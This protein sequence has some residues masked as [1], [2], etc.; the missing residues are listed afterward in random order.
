MKFQLG[1]INSIGKR[2][3]FLFI[4]QLIIIIFLPLSLL[5]QGLIIDHNCTDTSKIPDYWIEQAKS[6][7]K[8][9]YA[10]TSH[11]RQIIFGLQRMTDP[12]LSVYDP[13]LTFSQQNNSLPTSQGLC[14]MDGQLNE[15]YITPELYWKNGGDSY[16]RQVLN[17]Y[18]AINVSMWA[19]CRQ[20][21]HYTEK[22]VE[23]YLIV[24]SKLERNYPNVTFVYMTGNAQATGAAGYNRFLR[25]EQI[26]KYCRENNKILFDF[27]DLDAWFKGEQAT[28]TYNG[29]KIPKEHPQYSGSE[30]AHTTYTNC[31]NKGKAF[32]WMVAKLAGWGKEV[33]NCDYNQDGVVNEK[34]LR[35]KRKA[36]MQDFYKWRNECWWPMRECADFNQDG[37]INYNDFVEKLTSS[38][39]QLL[40]WMQECSLI[41]NSHNEIFKLN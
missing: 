21:D 40:N 4:F 34:D 41:K 29:Q 25:N 17:T 5:S 28:Y 20:L 19:W 32:W 26:R 7:I 11:G 6:L 10:H 12:S 33:G 16:T 36:V 14:I 23:D 15:T 30:A 35:Q 31:E 24:I 27:A 38:F 18:R 2:L 22:E 3:F 39:R 37:I 8:V 1:S 13:R 9:H